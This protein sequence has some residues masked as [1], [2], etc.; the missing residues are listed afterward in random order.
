MQ[1]A[2]YLCDWL[3]CDVP[4]CEDHA[5]HLG[6]NVDVCPTHNAYRGLLSRLLTFE[7]ATT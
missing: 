1:M 3:G 4:I 7:G 5:L 6:E 2:P